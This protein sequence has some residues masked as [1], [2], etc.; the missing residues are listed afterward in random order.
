VEILPLKSSLLLYC[1]WEQPRTQS[2][3][4]LSCTVGYSYTWEQN[5]P[6]TYFYSGLSCTVGYCYTW[7]H[8][9]LR[10]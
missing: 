5:K 8:N 4:G 1:I 7:E 9:K 10:T 6:R 3:S 2:Y